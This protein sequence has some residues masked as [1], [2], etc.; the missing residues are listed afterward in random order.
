MDDNQAVGR[1]T[2][3][4]VR[5]AIGDTD[6]NEIGAGKVR[7]L[8][9]RGSLET[10][11]K[12][13]GTL[14]DELIA[15]ATPVTTIPALPAEVQAAVQAMWASACTSAQLQSLRRTE[16][17]TAE[18]DAALLRVRSITHLHSELEQAASAAA[19]AKIVQAESQ[20]AA[21]AQI[22]ELTQEL[23][24]VQAAAA[25]AAKAA[26]LELAQVRVDATHAA[27]LSEKVGDMMRQE[28]SMLT[29]QIGELKS[30]LYERAKT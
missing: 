15:A 18:R 29:D 23:A 30:R 13:L 20:A 16:T 17:L 14:R 21:A 1:V 3:E 27:Q 22:G 10:I 11:Q 2:L 28:L 6:P 8:I 5:G 24:K 12:H 7:Q 9:G 25:E 19:V 4:D 26:A